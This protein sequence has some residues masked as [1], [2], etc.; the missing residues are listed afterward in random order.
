MGT[1]KL[2]VPGDPSG[3]QGSESSEWDERDD[4]LDNDTPRKRGLNPCEI[5]SELLYASKSLQEIAGY[6]TY[7]IL[8]VVARK[9]DKYG[10]LVRR[11]EGEEELP[12]WVKVDE[13]GM[14]IVENP[15][16][17]SKT[18]RQVKEYQGLDEIGTEKAWQEYL[19]DNPCL[20]D[21]IRRK[22]E[23]ER[24]RVART[25]AMQAN[26]ENSFR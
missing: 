2:Q 11:A 16:P 4:E 21:L 25:A 12:D 8:K 7:Q 19:C 13:D 26:L 23:M 5:V 3:D 22:E 15:V 24:R 17:F 14:R 1:G 20:V 6:D 10:R 9:R 18:F